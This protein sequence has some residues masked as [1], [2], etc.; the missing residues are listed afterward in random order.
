MYNS[1]GEPPFSWG[2]GG[3]GGYGTGS[4]RLLGA[5]NSDLSLMGNVVGM[6]YLDSFIAVTT[7]VHEKVGDL[8]AFLGL[9]LTR[10]K[11][12]FLLPSHQRRREKH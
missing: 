2:R 3:L 5:K 4:A 6:M 7:M 8:S 10:S 11:V 12:L 9:D 1:F